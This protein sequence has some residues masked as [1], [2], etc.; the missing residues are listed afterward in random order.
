MYMHNVNIF[1]YNMLLMQSEIQGI[2][3]HEQR[4]LEK[5][6]RLSLM[7]MKPKPKP[8]LKQQK[9][10]S[11]VKLT[12]TN[13]QPPVCLPMSPKIHKVTEPVRKPSPIFIQDDIKPPIAAKN[14]GYKKPSRA[15]FKPSSYNTNDS[16]L[17]DVLSEDSNDLSLSSSDS[18]SYGKSTSPKNKNKNKKGQKR[19]ASITSGST[20]E[21]KK[22]LK[23]KTHSQSDAEQVQHTATFSERYSPDTQSSNDVQILTNVTSLKD[24]KQESTCQS[25]SLNKRKNKVILL[26]L[27]PTVSSSLSTSP[28]PSSEASSCSMDMI[29]PVDMTK[30]SIKNPNKKKAF[31]ATAKLKSKKLNKEFLKRNISVGKKKNYKKKSLSQISSL[32]KQSTVVQ[33]EPQPTPHAQT[34]N[35]PILGVICGPLSTAQTVS[36]IDTDEL[37]T[38]ST[39]Q[40]ISEVN[41]PSRPCNE[42][43]VS[44]DMERSPLS[45][46]VV[47]QACML[48]WYDFVHT[49]LIANLSQVI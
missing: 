26:D 28:L 9:N 18:D 47:L 16:V 32:T 19:I 41:T 12:V 30:E 24:V 1:T 7:K 27:S 14:E 23:T 10:Q 48:S 5:A 35:T 36:T 11:T 29:L 31:V 20:P 49:V 13:P 37:M 33:K 2:P 43:T 46:S 44:D 15:C 39:S 40:H 4:E 45:R 6:M 42:G 21:T 8:K 34:D 22:S 25:K 3:Y 17:I 38:S